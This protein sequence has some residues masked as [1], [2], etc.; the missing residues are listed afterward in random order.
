MLLTLYINTIIQQQILHG[1]TIAKTYQKE[2][3][4]KEKIE[5]FLESARISITHPK[6]KE[7]FNLIQQD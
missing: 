7:L 5:S 2:G 3:I 6:L 4:P 1:S